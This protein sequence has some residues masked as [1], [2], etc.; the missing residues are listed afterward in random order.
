M[1]MSSLADRYA[2]QIL[3]ARAYSKTLTPISNTATLT[4]ADAYDIAKSLDTI[5]IAE[6][7]KPIGR[8]LGL[9]RDQ[10]RQQ[11][12][13]VD[14]QQ[15]LFWT[16]LFASTVRTL[17]EAVA[18]QSLTG[19][20]QPRLTPVIAFKLA[21]APAA[22]ATREELADCLDWMAH[23]LEI[24][25]NPYTELTFELADAIAAFGMHGTL[26]IGE[27]RNLSSATKHHL[28]QIMMDASVSLSCDGT[29]LGAGYGSNV[30]GNPINAL[31]Q[32]HQRL[33]DQ[34]QFSSLQEGEIISTGSWSDPHP[35]QAG[36]TWSTA[37][38][39]I[40]LAGLS[41]SFV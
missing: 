20:I 8:K 36:Q 26:L 4:L 13:T 16:T 12:S 41:V 1:L 9:I 5:R 15:T 35:I 39:G 3:E 24:I 30:L 22:N 40:S 14:T 6:G 34:R 18:I 32:L 37:F 19:A 7:E 25:V 29:L 23:G 33:N 28:G 2:H 38:S 31:W 27:Q 17:D 21:R 10:P 11:E